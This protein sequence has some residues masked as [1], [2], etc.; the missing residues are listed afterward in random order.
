ML[1]TLE[2]RILLATDIVGIDRDV[3]IAGLDAAAGTNDLVGWLNS[4]DQHNRLAQPLAVT[5][6]VIGA[7]LDS[8]AA[9]KLGLVDPLIHPATGFLNTATRSDDDL[10]AHLTSG[11]LD[12]TVGGYEFQIVSAAGGYSGDELSLDVVLR[13]IKP[14]VEFTAD[15]GAAGDSIGLDVANQLTATGTVD[16]TLDLDLTFGVNPDDEFFVVVHAFDASATVDE[17]VELVADS[18]APG[19]ATLQADVALQLTIN[20]ADSFILSVPKDGNTADSQD[21]VDA[22]NDSLNSTLATSSFA[23][24]VVAEDRSGTL[25]LVSQSGEIHSIQLQGGHELGF[26]E[27]TIA[28]GPISGGSQC[29]VD[30]RHGLQLGFVELPLIGR[31]LGQLVDVGGVLDQAFVQPLADATS[32]YLSTASQPTRL[33]VEAALQG[34]GGTFGELTILPPTGVSSSLAAGGDRV[35]FSLQMTAEQLRDWRFN[36]GDQGLDLGLMFL[37]EI[38]D[39]LLGTFTLDLTFGVN[40]SALPGEQ[41]AFF[42][43]FNQPATVDVAIL[44]NATTVNGAAGVL[45]I[46][47]DLTNILLDADLSIDL[48][49]SPSAFNV[50]GAELNDTPIDQLVTRAAT[51]NT[52]GGNVP[53]SVLPGV[54]G[55]SGGVSVG[56]SHSDIF[57]GMPLNVTGNNYEPF[58]AFDVITAGGLLGQLENLAEWFDQFEQASL[59]QT[60]PLTATTSFADVSDL[61]GAFTAQVLDPLRTIPAEEDAPTTVAFETVQ[62]MLGPLG[63]S[64]SYNHAS[65]EF[66]FDV[67]ASSAA[68]ATSEQAGIQFDIGSLTQIT[69]DDT[70]DLTSNSQS[71]LSVGLVMRPLGENN[72]V[73]WLRT[74]LLA[75]ERRCRVSIAG[76]V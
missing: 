52:I 4:V 64:G 43:R 34:V 75:R 23:A 40:L 6:Q 16:Y 65:R 57:D 67:T 10:V 69:T 38:P 58:A 42:V 71:T 3:L 15:F 36:L 48:N 32:G 1:E 49:S 2:P 45:G 47:G 17:A 72:L 31:S 22:L 29:T 60:I 18:S 68:V 70:A 27:A 53:L 56:L 13:A 20:G 44:G 26:D 21:L 33:G 66:L 11:A 73:H 7:E 5:G 30:C 35:E 9:V 25:A 24:R 54:S 74:R 62:Q 39:E 41:D 59:A 37:D 51:G 50:T 46:Q 61:S 19:A 8:A 28:T 63:I 14:D 55:F 76:R 12:G